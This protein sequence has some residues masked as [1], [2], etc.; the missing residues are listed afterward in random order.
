MTQTVV[1][2]DGFAL[3]EKAI[4]VATTI[5]RALQSSV[6]LTTAFPLDEAMVV[7]AGIEP[8]MASE[9]MLEKMRGY[10]ATQAQDARFTGIKVLT[11]VAVG[12]PAETI[13]ASAST[14]DDSVI[15]LATRG[16]NA[17]RSG[18]GSVAERVA[19]TAKVPVVVVP[20]QV[21][22][23]GIRCVM[24]ALD[25]SE[26]SCRSLPIAQRIADGAGA[27]LLLV[28]AVD[29]ETG[30]QLSDAEEG[31]LAS[32]MTRHAEAYLEEFARD[33]DARE[34]LRGNPI[35]ALV[36][37]SR[38]DDVDLVVMGSHGGSRR[39]RLE[40]GSVAAGVLHATERPVLIVPLRP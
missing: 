30:W 18:M 12:D 8:E 21:S 33:G 13:E 29:T 35:D 15:V 27:R 11:S 16:R 3:A 17:R 2:L 40:L 25:G 22:Y 7:L 1:P 24:V 14:D 37:R 4:P 19:R 28:E 34:I 6:Q 38:S 26:E 10:L 36:E 31:R 9:Q 32:A 20:P 5:A 39:T 23:Q